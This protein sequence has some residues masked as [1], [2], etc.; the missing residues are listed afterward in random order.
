LENE[1]E[2]IELSLQAGGGARGEEG[3]DYCGFIN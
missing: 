1:E 3:Q 2:D